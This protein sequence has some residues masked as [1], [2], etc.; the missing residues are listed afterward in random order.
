[1]QILTHNELS[2]NMWCGQAPLVRI[3]PSF[4]HANSW[5]SRIFTTP[6]SKL[7]HWDCPP[8][9]G[10][11]DASGADQHHSRTAHK[12]SLQRHN[13]LPS[14]PWDWAYCSRSSSTFAKPGTERCQNLLVKPETLSIR[15]LASWVTVFRAA[16]QPRVISLKKVKKASY[17]WVQYPEIVGKKSLHTRRLV[18]F[19]RVGKRQFLD[20]KLRSGN[21]PVAYASWRADPLP[22]D[23]DCW[24][25]QR[26]FLSVLMRIFL[27][28]KM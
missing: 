20:Y 6:H 25:A 28:L 8:D 1:M 16:N 23:G 22:L 10:D 26:L 27:L 12:K 2:Q 7:R 3:I 5:S 14:P 13:K 4:S 19:Y 21:H 11:T 9:R 18:S 17:W 24:L 15:A